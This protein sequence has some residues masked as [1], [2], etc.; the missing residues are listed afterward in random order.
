LQK[1]STYHQYSCV[2]CKHQ[3]IKELAHLIRQN[4]S[5]QVEKRRDEVMRLHFGQW[6][7]GYL[8]RLSVGEAL[9]GEA[10]VGPRGLLERLETAFGI[11][12][13]AG[14]EP[15]RVDVYA[16]RIERCVGG[17]AFFS[18]SWDVDPWGVA[19][20]LLHWRDE[21]ILAGWNGSVVVDGGPRL[22]ALAAVEAQGEV[23]L[24]AGFADRVRM[25][26][27]ELASGRGAGIEEL[28]LVEP[29]GQLP[30]VWQ[31]VIGLLERTGTR[32]VEPVAPEPVADPGT[33]LG[34]LQRALV[35]G[36]TLPE[37]GI[38][39]D[40]SL[41]LVTGRS[42]W[43][44]GEGLAAWLRQ[45]ELGAWPLQ[46]VVVRG[47]APAVLDEAL[48][49]Y[50]VPTLGAS[51]S[52]P[53]RPALQ[54]LPLI[55]SL[56]WAPKNPQ[57]MLELLS[58]PV[59]PL[60]RRLRTALL[61]ALSQAP[62]IGGTAWT[63]AWR[64]VAEA[65]DEPEA[66]EHQ[67]REWLEW[68]V[69]KPS[70]GVPVSVVR[71]V[72]DRVADWARTRA[73]SAD[74]GEGEADTL[75]TAA[76][77]A[78]Q[79]SQIL[80]GRT[81]ARLA[82]TQLDQLL[83]DV[84]RAGSSRRVSDG[85]SGSVPCVSNPGAV[86]AEADTVVWWGFVA[87]SAGAVRGPMWRTAERR[88]LAAAGV[89]V[90]EPAVQQRARAAAWVRPLLAAR[91][92]LLLVTFETLD[93]EVESPHPVWDEIRGRLRMSDRDLAALSGNWRDAMPSG[94]EWA[95][96]ELEERAREMVPAAAGRAVW[97]VDES[98]LPPRS[99]ESASS[100]E[101]LLGCPLKWGLN[102]RAKLRSK[103]IEL[104]A[105]NLLFGNLGHQLMEEF[106]LEYRDSLPEPADAREMLL[107]RFDDTVEG[108]A[109]SLLQP[110]QAETLQRVRF[111]IAR[112]GGVLVGAIR[113][114]GFR[115]EGCEVEVSGGRFA[116]TGFRGFIDLLLSHPQHG[117]VVVDLKWGGWTYRKKLLEEG[118]ALQLALYAHAVQKSGR[119]L[120]PTAY[121]VLSEARFLTLHHELFDPAV[122]V[123]G[124]SMEETIAAARDTY[125]EVREE[126]EIG[127][128]VAPPLLDEGSPLAEARKDQPLALGDPCTF[129]DFGGICGFGL[130]GA[131]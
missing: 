125:G 34:L 88:A 90:D 97:M 50:G 68:P 121:F 76:A 127:E 62:G 10:W 35:E 55:L 57:R 67:M 118:R 103:A 4:R 131:S 92:R 24:P 51:S 61:R 30:C 82:R 130:D 102:Y 89:E 33:D 100:L 91:E 111:Q 43:E 72:A 85:L 96:I 98:L 95:H 65:S 73:S 114:G 44:A 83:R 46:P 86:F 123:E 129:C 99:K 80:D 115:V 104:P 29:R 7:D 52:S 25:V 101:S 109:A 64:E 119:G 38:Q 93:G 15:E 78:R 59:S 106:L 36:T 75:A 37:G 26:E 53:W 14:A 79:L 128:L 107:E 20:E 8:P 56:L 69:F 120:P 110:G 6:L 19:R 74:E 45:L 13:Q 113:G 81:D 126:L 124:R 71:E 21:L 5:T 17:G 40:G 3:S 31:R 32:I 116:D 1:A 117:E 122:V 112:A 108:E 41:L 42:P 105:G 60:S 58:L 9:M 49:R 22:E 39:G 27:V 77:Q 18:R 84:T 63:K 66:V 54:V 28:F 12:G 47:A 16:Q 11:D 94:G 48:A 87:S 23:V 2:F 70:K